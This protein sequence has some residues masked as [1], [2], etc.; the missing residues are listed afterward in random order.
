ILFESPALTT[1]TNHNGGPLAFGP[2]GML[3]C[4][5][6][7]NAIPSRAQDLSTPIGKVIRIDR[8]GNAPPDNPYVDSERFPNAD[9]RVWAWGIRNS[10]GLTFHPNGLCYETENGPGCDDELNLIEAGNNYG[11]QS[12][13]AC[14]PSQQTLNTSLDPPFPY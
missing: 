8:D 12:G 6:G 7:E 9:P 14:Y 1:A 13:Y 10:F 2:D 3:Y 5:I 4:V 11:W